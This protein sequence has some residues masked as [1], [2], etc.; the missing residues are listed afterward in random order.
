VS[1]AAEQDSRNQSLFREVNER[2]GQL[3][4]GSDVGGHDSYICEC[5]NAGCTEAMELSRAEYEAV[6][7]HPNR[8]A[9][10]PNHENPV[11]ETVVERHGRYSVVEALAGEPSAAAQ[12]S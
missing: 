10:R 5:G 9:V 8:F 6:R 7:R 2:I 1:E 3:A 11:M 4:N 12:A